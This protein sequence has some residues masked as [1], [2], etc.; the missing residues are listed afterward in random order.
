MKKQ[1]FVR[2]S[3]VP[4][5]H[6]NYSGS[7]LSF[8]VSKELMEMHGGE[9]GTMSPA[10]VGSAFASY[11]KAQRAPVPMTELALRQAQ[12]Y[13]SSM[14]RGK[15]EAQPGGSLSHAPTTQILK[16][17]GKLYAFTVKDNLINQRVLANSCCKRGAKSA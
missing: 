4:R 8:F 6:S 1:L 17:E 10:G 14:R 12:S 7:S 16:E 2:F 15:S 13:R 11:V 3:H 5:T 9:V